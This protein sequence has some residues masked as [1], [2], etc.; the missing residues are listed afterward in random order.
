MGKT[1]WY[2]RPWVAPFAFVVVAFVAFSLPPYLTLNPAL[3]RVP[4]PADYAW[5]FPALVGHVIFGSVA[6]LTC[7]LQVWPWFRQRY[8]VAHRRIGRVYVFGG[9]LPAG[10]L[11]LAVGA[12]SPFGPLNQI[13]NV[14]MGS[15][16]LT[17]TVVGFR[18][19]RQRRFVDHRRWMIRSFALTAS[20]MSNRIWAVVATI[21]FSPQLDTTFGGSQVALVQAISG[22]AAWMGWV[23]PFLI[24]E[25]W[26]ERGDAKKRRT[27]GTSERERQPVGV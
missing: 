27:R 19:A 23:V 21:V 10:V 9:V 3:S 8:P 6:I 16:W 24:A 2:R 11:A 1:K 14:L 4:Q 20:I 22:T 25:W 12:V 5:H 13:G 18:M 26:L 7:V 17:F 15:L